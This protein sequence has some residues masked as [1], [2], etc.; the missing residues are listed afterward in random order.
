[1]SKIGLVYT[2]SISLWIRVPGCWDG[3]GKSHFGINLHPLF[4]FFKNMSLDFCIATFRGSDFFG[5]WAYDVIASPNNSLVIRSDFILVLTQGSVEV[6]GGG[7][8]NK[9]ELS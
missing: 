8:D 2:A 4:L 3:M 7:G 5:G 1:M 9:P 6:R